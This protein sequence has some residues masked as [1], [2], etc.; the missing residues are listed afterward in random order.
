MSVYWLLPDGARRFHAFLNDQGR[1]VCGKY[2]RDDVI[3]ARRGH[4]YCALCDRRLE[5]DGR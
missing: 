2:H 1:S 4:V 5:K 3:P